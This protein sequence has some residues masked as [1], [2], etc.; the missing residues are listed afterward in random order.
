MTVRIKRVYEPRAPRDGK[1]ILVER[2]WPRGL[3]KEAV[4][5][6]AWLKDVA[7]STGLRQWFGHDVRRWDEFRQRYESELKANQSAWESLMEAGS[8]RAVT[9]LYSARDEQHNGARVL[10]DF[11]VK[12]M[13]RKQA[14]AKRNSFR[15][16]GVARRN[17]AR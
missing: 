11:L 13:P 8:R 10:R 12:R 5:A 7:P 1:R 15:T 6:D 17:R 2:L 3:K 16:R 4:R 14:R 9:L